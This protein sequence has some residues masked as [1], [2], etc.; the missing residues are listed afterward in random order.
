MNGGDSAM[1]EANLY[2]LNG[3]KFLVVFK[4]GN[5]KVRKDLR[6]VRNEKT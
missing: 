3:L 4:K 5:R 1:D 2:T 6:K